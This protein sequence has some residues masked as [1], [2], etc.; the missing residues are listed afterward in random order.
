M[1]NVL[2]AI[3]GA[4]LVAAATVL[5]GVTAQGGAHPFWADQVVWI[6][7]AVAA[8]LLLLANRWP[9]AAVGAAVLCAVAGA[10]SARFGKQV[11]AA[12]YAENGLA[13]QFWYF[14]WIALCIG[15]TALIGMG[16]LR[17]LA[18]RS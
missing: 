3:I 2:F 7:L 12:S 10:A 5:L 6:G 15:V 16:F 17:I 14:G 13:G 18:R 11:F 4:G 9:S 8:V 1:S